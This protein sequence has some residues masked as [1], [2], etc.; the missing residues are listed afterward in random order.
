MRQRTC[1]TQAQPRDELLTELVYELLDAHHD[2]TELAT[3]EHLH[4]ASPWREHLDYLRA[5]Q[6]TGR[7]LLAHANTEARP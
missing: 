7:E 4:E 6:R 3:A 5:L 2:T 1:T